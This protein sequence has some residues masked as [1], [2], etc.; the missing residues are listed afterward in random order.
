[1]SLTVVIPAARFAAGSGFDPT[2]E[3]NLPGLSSLLGRADLSDAP[4]ETPEALLARWF[5]AEGVSSALLA[6]RAE[7]P[8]APAGFWLRADPVH[9]RP[10]RDRA[11]LVTHEGLAV[12]R[13][14][15]DALIEALNRLF[16]A[17]G[18]SFHA[19]TPQR[20]YLR[21][22]ADPGLVTVPLARVLGDDIHAN[23]PKGE[24]A[25]RW[26]ALLNEMQMLLYTHP[27]NDARDLAGRL[28]I[29]SIWLWGEGRAP[30]NLR[31]PFPTI[32]GDAADLCALCD[33]AGV[34]RHTV[35]ERFATLED[36]ALVWL[37][38]LAS[39]GRQGDLMAWRDRLSQLDRDWLQPLFAAWKSG[40]IPHLRLVFPDAGGNLEADLA[41]SAR[42]KFWRGAAAPRRLALA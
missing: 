14:E 7:W 29:N 27:V 40:A 38:A 11:L 20:W 2:Q 37:D 3:L 12:E 41:A 15:A 34:P 35:P 8:E 1:M 28:N 24:N 16:G 4:G 21:L 30:E 19:P 25:L 9:L 33:A 42:W 26:H 39:A 5:G 31:R 18:L 32:Y 22:D 10:D 36:G 6:L 17:D 23:L 13:T